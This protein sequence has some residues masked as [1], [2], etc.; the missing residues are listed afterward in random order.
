MPQL[1]L[2]T[3][4]DLLDHLID[5]L[6]ANVSSE[7]DRDARRAIFSALRIFSNAHRWSFYYQRGRISTQAQFGTASGVTVQYTAAT[8]QLVVS[9]ATWPTWIV[10]GIVL[11]NNIEYPVVSQTDSQTIVLDPNNSPSADMAAGSTFM[12]YL[13]T[14]ALPADFIS[15]DEL[16][17]ATYVMG[18]DYVHPS[19]WLAKHRLV[20]TPA[21][22]YRYTITGH[23]SYFGTMAVR[24]FPAPDTTY[25]LD[26]IYQRRARPLQID[27]YST[28][29]VNVSANNQ[30]IAGNG[31]AWTS[32]MIGCVIRFSADGVSLPTGLIGSNPYN[33]ERVIIGVTN[34]TSLTLDATIPDSWNGVKYLISDPVDIE[35]GAMLTAFLR[36]CEWQ[37]ARSRNMRDRTE[38]EQE[39]N[40]ALIRA[41]EA[42]SRSFQERAAG[43]VPANRLRL[44]YMPRGGDI[45]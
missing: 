32:K 19:Q 28:G 14:Y 26:Y 29:T 12:A 34:G 40:R 21:T 36:C 1:P 44:A 13:D 35:D 39:Y 31:T 41:K 8:Q 6:G 38:I 3:Y 18:L 17:N 37:L 43:V 22:P 30:I 2:V 45:G 20:Y 24:L 5:F 10:Q 9:G 23:P 11:L 16:I 33:Y 15:M 25:Q 4:Q 7:A 27:N 42:D